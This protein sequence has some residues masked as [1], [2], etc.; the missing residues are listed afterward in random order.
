MSAVG[1]GATRSTRARSALRLIAWSILFFALVIYSRNLAVKE[2]GELPVALISPSAGIGLVWL[3][4]ART[5]AELVVDY[6]ALTVV[7]ALGLWFADVVGWTG[8][9]PGAMYLLLPLA[10]LQYLDRRLPDAPV[11]APA[12]GRWRP[13]DDAH[14]ARV[15]P[16]PARD[17][18]RRHRV[19][20]HPHRVR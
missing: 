1:V 9:V 8:A 18:P 4:S 5:R 3:A 20:A 14:P 2:P 15:R 12:L 11:G 10:G 13:Q 7:A 17:D 6:V 19:L 16:G